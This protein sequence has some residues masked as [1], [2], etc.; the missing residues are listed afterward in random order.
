M[1]LLHIVILALVQGATEVLPVSSSAHLLLVHAIFGE[2]EKQE[3]LIIDIALHVGTLMAVLI[4]FRRD[5]WALVKNIPRWFDKSRRREGEK[6]GAKILFNVVIASLPV[7][8]A[9][10][11]IH[12]YDPS[13]SRSLAVL[14]WGLIGFGILLWIA[15]RFMP[16]QLELGEMT[17]KKAL[18]IGVAQIFSLV[19][20]TSRSG[21]TMTA[22]RFMGFKRVEAARFSLFLAIVAI[23]GAGVLGGIGLLEENNAGLTTAALIGA[24]ISCGASWVS[25][26]MLMRWLATA[27]FTPFVI[28]RI[29]LGVAL[30]VMMKMGIIVV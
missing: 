21:V 14:P 28:Y 15:D 27:S 29:L 19:P 9:G 10:L 6:T 20:G 2:G 26:V 11:L 13:W 3:N 4:Y 17:W 5:L 23:S 12:I 25:I 24:I 7:V 8:V 30:L 18:F 1:P 16:S 22:A